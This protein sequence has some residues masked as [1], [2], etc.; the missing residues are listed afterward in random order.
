M[1]APWFQ[2]RLVDGR[3]V[4]YLVQV[5]G[6]PIPVGVQRAVWTH[7][8]AAKVQ[9]IC[10]ALNN[11]LLREINYAIAVATRQRAGKR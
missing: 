11:G 1:S 2:M 6:K 7:P 5:D 4:I 3:S 8:S 10:D 9:V